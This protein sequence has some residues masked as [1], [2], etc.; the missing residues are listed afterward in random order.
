MPAAGLRDG[1]TGAV[2]NQGTNGYGWSSTPYSESNGHV[3][4]FDR[5]NVNPVNNGNFSIGRTVR[6]VAR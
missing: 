6:C 5:N 2:A 4:I 3:L 1:S